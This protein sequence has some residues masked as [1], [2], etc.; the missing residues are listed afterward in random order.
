MGSFSFNSFVASITFSVNSECALPWLEYDNIATLGSFSTNCS[1]L[2]L[3][4]IAISDNWSGFGFSFNPASPNINVP[5]SPYSQFGT[6]ITKNADTNFVSGAVFNIC[7]AG[8]KVSAVE[9]AAPETKPS[10]FVSSS[11]TISIPKYTGFSTSCFAC[12]IVIP[13][14]FLSSYNSCTYFS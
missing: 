11:F 5:L 9:C 14:F 1:K 10:A 6:T 12:S 2:L 8:L 3:D 13:L 7:N 4:D